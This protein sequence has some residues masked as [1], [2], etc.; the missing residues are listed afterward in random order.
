MP[1]F[2]ANLTMLYTEL[3]FLDRFEAAARDGFAG[4]EFLFPYGHHKAEIAERLKSAG[5]QLAL[6]NL[7]PGNWDRG[8]RGIACHPD[9]IGEFRKGVATAIDYAQALGNPLL[10]CMAGLTPPGIPD[11]I[12]GETYIANL[13]FAAEAAA[14]A[15]LRLVIEPINTRDIPGYYLNRSS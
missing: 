15:D 9:R 7:P 6:F 8:E 5:L 13:R 2:A 12:I 4:V 1:K 11:A 10:H 3:A 14:E